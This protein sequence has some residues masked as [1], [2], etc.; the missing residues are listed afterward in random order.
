MSGSLIAD[1]LCACAACTPDWQN[2]KTEYKSSTIC[3]DATSEEFIDLY[4]DDDFR[5]NWDTMIIA[6]S[7]RGARLGVG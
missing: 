7:V 5:P 1:L 6:H 4:F 2:G 3:P